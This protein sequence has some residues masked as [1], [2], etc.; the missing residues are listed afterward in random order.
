MTTTSPGDVTSVN[1]SQRSGTSDLLVHVPRREVATGTVF[2][3]S[4]GQ[5][6]GETCLLVGNPNNELAEIRYSIGGA[7]AQTA[8]IPLLG[9]VRIPLTVAGCRVV[10]TASS[11][12]LPVFV[13][14]VTDLRRFEATFILPG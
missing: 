14:L 13:Q 7:A 8:Q 12:N 9:F 5:V 3:V 10:V 11:Q 1:L 6:G 4:V 2:Q